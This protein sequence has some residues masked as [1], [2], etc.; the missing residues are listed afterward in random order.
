LPIL[1]HCW[2]KSWKQ[3][4]SRIQKVLHRLV[5]TEDEEKKV[6]LVITVASWLLA[7]LEKK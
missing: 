6:S 1:E 7:I 3:L 2:V 4:V 5:D